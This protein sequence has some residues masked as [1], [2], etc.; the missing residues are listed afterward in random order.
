MSWNQRGLR[1]AAGALGA[2]SSRVPPTHQTWEQFPFHLL[3]AGGPE[4]RQQGAHM[5]GLGRRGEPARGPSK[6]AR[7]GASTQA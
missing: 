5:A 3:E 7:N 2:W 6:E 1:E 4:A